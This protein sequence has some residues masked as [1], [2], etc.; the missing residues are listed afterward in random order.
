[1]SKQSSVNRVRIPLK[2]GDE[3]DVLTPWRKVINKPSGVCK[4]IKHKYNK[5]LRKQPIYISTPYHLFDYTTPQPESVL[6]CT[7]GDGVWIN[8]DD[9]VK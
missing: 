5:R 9:M 4:Y 2:G 6:T 3:Q 1:V 8:Y 7:E